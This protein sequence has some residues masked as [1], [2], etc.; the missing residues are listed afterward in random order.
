[1]PKELH[2]SRVSRVLA[3]Q[4]SQ[5]PLPVNSTVRRPKRDCSKFLDRDRLDRKRKWIGCIIAALFGGGV[6]TL[7]ACGGLL[8]TLGTESGESTPH[9]AEQWFKT[10]VQDDPSPFTD[11]QHCTD[12]G[13]DFS[14]H[15]RFRF[16]DVEDLTPII[17]LHGLILTQRDG[18]MRLENLPEWYDPL[19]VPADALR[20]GRSGTEPILLIADPNARIAYLELVHL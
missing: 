18:S 17:K 1:M 3:V 20:F 19:G 6:I 5:G 9:D 8:V 11:I 14:H 16:S 2:G 4:A 10:V 13:I 15:F 12:Q 7:L